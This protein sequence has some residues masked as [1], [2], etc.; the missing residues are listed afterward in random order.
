MLKRRLRCLHGTVG[1]VGGVGSVGGALEA[2]R[3][4]ILHPRSA[5]DRH[6]CGEGP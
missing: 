2:A 1:N 6:L 5:P 3:L 4:L